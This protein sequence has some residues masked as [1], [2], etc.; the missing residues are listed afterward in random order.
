M[1][2]QG[3][4]GVLKS[5]LQTSGLAGV[6]TGGEPAQIG[7]QI[8]GSGQQAH[9]HLG[10]GH[11]AIGAAAVGQI[12][13]PAA[14]Q[15][16]P[17]TTATANGIDQQAH[18]GHQHQKAK[19]A[20]AAKAKH[21]DQERKANSA[22]PVA[23]PIAPSITAA[24]AIAAAPTAITAAHGGRGAKAAA[25]NPATTGRPAGFRPCHQERHGEHWQSQ[26]TQAAIQKPAGG[27][28]QSAYASDQNL[29][30]TPHDGD[31]LEAIGFH[32]CLIP[33]AAAGQNLAIEFH[34]HQLGPIATGFEHLGQGQPRGTLARLAIELDR[35]RGH[36]AIFCIKLRIKLL[37]QACCPRACSRAVVAAAGSAAAVI[38]RTTATR[39]PPA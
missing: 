6:G 15:G 9:L 23:T 33:P 39:W 11:R 27:E 16:G 25:P 20:A 10:N 29:G 30:T 12:T 4:G 31:H 35:D 32:H 8:A 26:P 14:S 36:G 38:A 24:A 21:R 17:A 28:R 22:A 13:A 7:L 37:N 1:A 34:H 18:H 19:Q 3:E 2:Q 5:L